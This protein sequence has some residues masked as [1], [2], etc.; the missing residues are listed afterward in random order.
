MA[1]KKQAPKKKAPKRRAKKIAEVPPVV[2]AAT[3]IAGEAFAS[4]ATL[5]FEL[6][7]DLNNVNLGLS[8]NWQDQLRQAAKL[9]GESEEKILQ[10]F[11]A[12][13]MRWKPSYL[14]IAEFAAKARQ[15]EEMATVEEQNKRESE[16]LGGELK[17]K[18]AEAVHEVNQRASAVLGEVEKLKAEL[19]ASS[20]FA[21]HPFKDVE[22]SFKCEGFRW[23]PV[24]FAAHFN[25]NR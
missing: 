9:T 15:R 24:D 19:P 3:K 6:V 8:E 12:S 17:A 21:I 4:G 14:H 7:P 18:H 25:L 5:R 1:T 22:A 2:A 16:A 11:A 20:K 10:R 13:F 23:T